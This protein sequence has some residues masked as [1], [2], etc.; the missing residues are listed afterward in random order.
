M[1]LKETS[2]MELTDAPSKISQDPPT[3]ELVEDPSVAQQYPKPIWR[4]FSFKGRPYYHNRETKTTM[5][6][7]P[8]KGGVEVTNQE[9]KEN[10]LTDK[11]VQT[12]NCVSKLSSISSSTLK[13]TTGS[14]KGQKRAKQIMTPRPGARSSIRAVSQVVEIMTKEKAWKWL[15][16]LNPGFVLEDGQYSIP[17]SDGTIRLDKLEACR[18]KLCK[19]GVPLKP[20]VS[21]VDYFLDESLSNQLEQWVRFAIVPHLTEVVVNRCYTDKHAQLA[22]IKVNAISNR[23]GWSVD[24][25]KFSTF[26][27]LK[28]HLR[29]NGLAI[30]M[31]GHDVDEAMTFIAQDHAADFPVL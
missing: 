23:D 13:T 4:E 21:S 19:D 27:D 14:D 1:L 22:L 26:S 30:P 25:K 16:E 11:K 8:K 15:Q 10:L 29:R 5:W 17:Y 12:T 7:K 31:K 28:N 9:Y 6:N 2:P 24:D 3:A 20:G 18:A